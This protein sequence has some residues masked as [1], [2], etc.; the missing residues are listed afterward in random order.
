[1]G[2]KLGDVTGFEG[3]VTTLQ[4]VKPGH[5]RQTEASLGYE[6]GRLAQGYLILLL[7]QTL[8]PADFE[9]DG[10]TMRSG[11][12]LGLPAASESEDALRPR[13][14]DVLMAERGPDGYAAL[15][16][17]ALSPGLRRGSE[18]I[19][20]VLPAIRHVTGRI[21]AEQYPMGGGGLQWRLVRECDFLIAVEV[22]PSGGAT[23]PHFSVHLPSGGYEARARLRQ[24][25]MTAH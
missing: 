4:W 9:F 3:N 5:E 17:A 12:R 1:M 22:S 14:H 10:T 7:N 19:A 16:R 8:T 2:L 6:T 24:Y 23:T 20:K 18:R 25:M 11:G 15:Q 21:P 13:V